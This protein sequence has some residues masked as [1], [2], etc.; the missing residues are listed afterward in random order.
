[1]RLG[2]G[3]AKHG[4]RSRSWCVADF[5]DQSGLGTRLASAL[6]T[7]GHACTLVYASHTER[8]GSDEFVV[9][10]ANSSDYA[11]LRNRLSGSGIRGDRIVHLWCS[12][13]PTAERSPLTLQD[14]LVHGV[15]SL[16]HI[17]RTFVEEGSTLV[18]LW[19]LSRSGQPLSATTGSPMLENSFVWA[20][21]Q[22]LEQEYRNLTCCCL[23]LQ[24]TSA[25]SE[26]S[27]LARSCQSCFAIA[28][29]GLSS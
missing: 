11:A 26:G 14:G 2:T 16:F 15:E 18:T 25:D 5:S 8:L 24:F 9:D 1:M 12:E 7:Q 20:F 3:R 28:D 6:R 17:A 10:P 13:M 27:V 22:G 4:L 19:V 29:R 21:A 23:D